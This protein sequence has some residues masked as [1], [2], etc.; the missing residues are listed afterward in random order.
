MATLLHREI[1]VNVWIQFLAQREMPPFASISSEPRLVHERASEH[2]V[3]SL[4]AG[5]ARCEQMRHRVEAFDLFNLI[6][7]LVQAMPDGSGLDLNPPALDR[8]LRIEGFQWKLLGSAS[9][10]EV[11]G[12]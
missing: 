3:C 12:K 1:E 9:S 6:R 4:L 2:P 11:F 10:T 7:Y 5:L 8:K